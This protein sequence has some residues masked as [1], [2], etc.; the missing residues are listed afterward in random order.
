M[1]YM[2]HVTSLN[3]CFVVVFALIAGGATACAPSPAAP[4]ATTAAE[5]RAAADAPILAAGT[6]D[7]DDV[8][9]PVGQLVCT[10][11]NGPDGMSELYLEWNGASATGVLRRTVPSGMVYLQRIQAER[12]S[13]MIVVDDARETDLVVHAAVVRQENGKQLMRIGD[14]TTHSWATCL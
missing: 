14:A 13:G 1:C 8:E 2:R 12:S 3:R 4:A 6:K 10:T 11:K 5:L 7:V 9:R